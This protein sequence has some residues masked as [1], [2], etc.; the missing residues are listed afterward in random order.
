MRAGLGSSVLCAIVAISPASR[1]DER[2]VKIKKKAAVHSKPSVDAAVGTATRAVAV[3][4][5]DD[6]PPEKGWLPVRAEVIAP[7]SD[8]FVRTRSLSVWVRARD[9]RRA[10]CPRPA[11]IA[12][13]EPAGSDDSLKWP[14]RTSAGWANVG[15]VRPAKD[16]SVEVVA[17]EPKLYCFLSSHFP[18][19][20]LRLCVQR[21][22]GGG[23]RT[24]G[25]PLDDL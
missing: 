15:T 20:R 10:K 11:L 16:T 21:A 8:D 18:G 1:A 12:M 6:K 2:C 5:E 7:F 17:G 9:T 23:M 4:V 19:L 14:D 24:I 25:D 22:D 13:L 3:F